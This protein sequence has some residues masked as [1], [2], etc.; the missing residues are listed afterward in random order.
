[1]PSFVPTLLTLP[2]PRRVFAQTGFALRNAFCISSGAC[3]L[4]CVREPQGLQYPPGQRARR[5]M[6]NAQV[7][8]W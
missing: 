5:L 1:M 6:R 2:P 8:A 7:S 3:V 4:D